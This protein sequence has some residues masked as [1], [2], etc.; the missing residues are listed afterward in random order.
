MERRI[1]V[2]A[3]GEHELADFSE[4][5][6]LIILLRRILADFSFRAE[7][8]PIKS[9]NRRVHVRDDRRARGDR[10][11]RKLIAILD[12]AEK[13]RFDAVCILFDRDGDKSREL[14]ATTAQETN[15]VAIPR[16][17]GVAVESYDA[18]Y[19][20]DELALTTEL[21]VNVDRQSDPEVEKSPKDKVRRLLQAHN[22]P[23]SQRE[24][25]SAI[26]ASIS[27]Q[28]LINRCP[29]GFAVF[30][31][32]VKSISENASERNIVAR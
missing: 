31:E 25:Y 5:G 32:R 6:S 16:A 7:C 9:F 18:W 14:A 11:A 8:R 21:K 17:V 12:E 4:N 29:A 23:V 27:L 1:L 3:E 20:A 13:G 15:Y 10:H 19:L 22:Y 30:H 2:V 28:L 24:F 26:A